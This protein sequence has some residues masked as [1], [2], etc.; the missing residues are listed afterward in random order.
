MGLAH[1]GFYPVDSGEQLGRSRARWACGMQFI[2]PGLQGTEPG[3]MRR[4]ALTVQ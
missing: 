4:K 3:Q 1:P 2:G